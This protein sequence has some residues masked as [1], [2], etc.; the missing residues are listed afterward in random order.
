MH[1]ALGGGDAVRERV[2]TFVVTGVP[3]PR[4]LDLA[5]G[6]L[7]A[8]VTDVLEQRL[9]R[10]VEVT[11]EIDDATIEREG[12]RLLVAGSFVV[13]GDRETA[14]EERHDLQAL[15]DRRVAEL[16]LFEH[17]RVGPERDARSGVTT[18]RLR[19]GLQLSLRDAG[20]DGTPAG[21]HGRVLLSVGLATAVDF[22][23]DVLRQRV[24]D[25]HADA[26]QPTRHLVAPAAELAARVQRGHDDLGRRLPFVLRVLVD[27]DTAAVVGDAHTAVGEQRHVDPGAHARHG[28]VDRVVDDLPHEVMEAGGAGRTDVH[29]GPFADRI[30]ALENLD[31]LGRVVAGGRAGHAANRT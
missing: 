28:L 19:D 27:R 31:V 9:L 13:Q 18:F 3:L 11:D 1:P 10:L 23:Q 15:G 6:A 25:R 2:Q 29:A 14:V 22:E 21:L 24:H 4:D 20:L 17:L 7:V 5:L 26:V 8:E 16:D 12:L 30:E